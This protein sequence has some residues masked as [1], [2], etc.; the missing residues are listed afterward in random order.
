MMA[1]MVLVAIVTASG[2]SGNIDNKAIV[3]IASVIV[4]VMSVLKI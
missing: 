1:T 3:V 4:V 2:A